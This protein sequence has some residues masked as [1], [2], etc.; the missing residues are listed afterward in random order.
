MAT[1]LEKLEADALKLTPDE[2]ATLAQ[3]LLGSLEDD[4]EIQE[5]WAVEVERR[6]AEVESGAVQ[7]IPIAEALSQVRARLK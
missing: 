5:A 1:E 4:A 2:R 6:I 7:L 3:R